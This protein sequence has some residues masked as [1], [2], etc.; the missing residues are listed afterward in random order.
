VKSRGVHLQYSFQPRGQRGEEIENP[1]FD[2]LS[3]LHDEGSILH[4]A[5]KM[6]ASYRTVW[7]AI[8]NWEEILG[9]PLV[10]WTQGQP[11][12]LTPFAQRLLWAETRARVRLAPHI[13]A[14]RAELERVVSEALDGTQQVLTVF[15]S[16]DLALPLLRERASKRQRLH[17][18]LSFAGSMDALRALAEGRCT[19]AGFHVPPLAE[20]SNEFARGLKPLLK[21]GRHKLIGCTR[22][23]VGL[24]V[25]RGNPLQL[26]GLPDLVHTGARFIN[27]QVGS[28][29]RLLTEHLLRQHAIA[30][31]RIG[32]FADSAENSHIAVAAAIAS[33]AADCGIGVEA[34]A[35]QFGLDFIELIREDYF[36]VCLKDSLEDSAVVKLRE[37]LA[38]PVWQKAVASLPGYALVRSG[39]V[40]SMTRALPWWRFRT[41]K[42]HKVH[43]T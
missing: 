21:P 2:L 5:K 14:L 9:E 43:S 3:A 26:R 38:D 12:R 27:R 6:G 16:H 32:G 8:R 17:I 30:H 34:A 13:E 20:S 41:P 37:A 7:G 11:A 33:G 31:D 36:L 15:A 25:A 35:R 42:E 24:M 40:L 29:T 4:A 19:V 28:G 18:D 10:T 1:L 39:E 23:T 22:R